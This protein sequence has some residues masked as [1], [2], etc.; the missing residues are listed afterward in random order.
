MQKSGIW[1]E[2]SRVRIEDNKVYVQ[3]VGDKGDKTDDDQ[4]GWWF[5]DPEA[6]G[7]S[8]E[9]TFRAMA[10]GLDSAEQMVLAKL[11]ANE[12]SEEADGSKLLCKFI[13]IQTK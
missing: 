3:I 9:A 13:R 6:A 4:P 12:K 7:T 2:V 1:L 8:A 10:R 11:E 5:V